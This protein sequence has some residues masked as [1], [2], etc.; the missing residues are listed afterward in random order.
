MSSREYEVIKG[1]TW[2]N[3]R[4]YNPMNYKY[5]SMVQKLAAKNKI[6]NLAST[7][8]AA[9]RQCLKDAG[10]EDDSTM[11]AIQRDEEYLPE[12]TEC[13]KSKI[14]SVIEQEEDPSQA[15]DYSLD[16]IKL[17]EMKELDGERLHAAFEKEF[18]EK[19]GSD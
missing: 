17:A 12:F 8:W 19:W 18:K 7:A 10:R 14:E 1:H 5:D 6:Y 13:V 4:N 2:Y 9:K 3:Q 15:L 16:V 11:L